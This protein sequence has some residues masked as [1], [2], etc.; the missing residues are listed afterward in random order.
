MVDVRR[1]RLPDHLELS[2]WSGSAGA[3]PDLA[4]PAE[5]AALTTD[6]S[7]FATVIGRRFMNG[8][9]P[10]HEPGSLPDDMN[11]IER[12]QK[13]GDDSRLYFHPNDCFLCILVERS[14]NFFPKKAKL[15]CC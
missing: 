14:V 9:R 7:P 12:S 5:S 3:S 4:S 2:G 13:G 8:G 11:S 6:D 1:C 10:V 15:H